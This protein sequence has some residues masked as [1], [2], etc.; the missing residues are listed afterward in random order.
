M[1]ERTQEIQSHIRDYLRGYGG[2]NL[3]ALEQLANFAH[4]P[5]MAQREIDQRAAHIVGVFSDSELHAIA[6]GTVDMQALAREVM[7]E[8]GGKA[9]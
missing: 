4:W 5:E 7:T 2:Q 8:F 6:T 1:S 3:T 9:S